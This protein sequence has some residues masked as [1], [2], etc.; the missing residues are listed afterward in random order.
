MASTLNK[1][2]MPFGP[3]SVSRASALSISEAFSAWGPRFQRRRP[4]VDAELAQ[5]IALRNRTMG[6]GAD[7][8]RALRQRGEIDVRRDVGFS[9][10]GQRVG[11][12]VTG[13][14]LQRFAKSLSRVAI[15]DD[16][17]RRRRSRTR[18]P[19]SSATVSGRHS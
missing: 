3:A 7:D 19:S 9:R 17:Q 11:E 2:P 13:D 18:R 12:G 1:S 15:V 10:R 8:F 5:E 6:A 16:E 14:G 4:F